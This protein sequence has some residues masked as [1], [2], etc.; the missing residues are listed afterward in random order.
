MNIQLLVSKTCAVCDQAEAIWR[1]LSAQRSIRFN[2]IHI[3][4]PAGQALAQRLNLRT[5]PAVLIDGTLVGVGVQTL[6]QANAIVDA[7]HGS[8]DA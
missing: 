3:D 4:D 2:L 1:T 5:V 7:Q 8:N 6:E